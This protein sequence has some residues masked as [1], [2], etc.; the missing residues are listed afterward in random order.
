[1]DWIVFLETVDTRRTLAGLGFP[2]FHYHLTVSGVQGYHHS[3]S[4][5][6]WISVSLTYRT[7]YSNLPGQLAEELGLGGS[8]DDHLGGTGIEPFHRLIQG[9]M[10]T[11]SQMRG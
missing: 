10:N 6:A 4:V 3:L 11:N 2:S 8:A 1:M 9:F 5:A 7:C